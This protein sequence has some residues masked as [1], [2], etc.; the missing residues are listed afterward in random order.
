LKISTGFN[1]EDSNAKD[2]HNTKSLNF[3]LSR[4]LKKKNQEQSIKL[5]AGIFG[6]KFKA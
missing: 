2:E 5:N 1:K 6:K 3:R 4:Y